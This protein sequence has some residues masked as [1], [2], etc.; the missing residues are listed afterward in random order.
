[1]NDKIMGAFFKLQDVVICNDVGVIEQFGPK[2]RVTGHDRPRFKLPLNHGQTILHLVSRDF[3]KEQRV[4]PGAFSV[5][6]QR[7]AVAQI[8]R[9]VHAR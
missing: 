8:W 5:A 1:M 2:I 9:I 7:A 3:V 6:Q 4:P